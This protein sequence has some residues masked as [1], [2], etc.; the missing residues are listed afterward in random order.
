MADN[1]TDISGLKVLQA[2]NPLSSQTWATGATATAASALTGPSWLA[3]N[4]AKVTVIGLGLLLIAA[5]IF[6]FDKTR[7]IVVS[8]GKTAAEAAA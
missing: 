1:L 8:A 6:S 2:L 7:D 5:G 3:S 4:L